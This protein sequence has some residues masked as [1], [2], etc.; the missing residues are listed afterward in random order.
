[1]IDNLHYLIPVNSN[2]DISSY[3]KVL[4][5][6]C[7]VIIIDQHKKIKYVNQKFTGV[8]GF[9]LKKVAGKNFQWLDARN[10]MDDLYQ[11]FWKKLNS[12]FTWQGE[13]FQKKT[14]NE[15]FWQQASVF[16]FKNQQGEVYQYICVGHD[17]T[18]Y[19]KAMQIKNQFLANMSHELRTPL[20]SIYSLSNLLAET[21]LSDEQNDYMENILNATNVLMRLLED[22][23][24]MN[25]IETGQIQ[26][27]HKL[28]NPKIIVESLYKMFQEKSKQKKIDFDLHYDPA[29]PE[30][31]SGDPYRLKQILIHLLENAFKY[32]PHGNIK[33]TCALKERN[34]NHTIFNFSI[35]DTGIG[36]SSDNLNL[37]Q[38]KFQQANMTD[39]RTY[40]G[41]GLGLTIVKKLIQL[42]NGKFEINS[43]ENIGTKVSFT[44]PMANTSD[45]EKNKDINTALTTD[46]TQGMRVLIA[47]DVDI[48]QLVIK[49]HMQK[50]G[51]IA[52]F[53]ENGKIA[54]E[55]LKKNQYHIVLM[56]MQMPVMDGYKAI[57]IIRNEL[58]EPIKNIPIISITASVMG[59]APRKCL[60]VG[61]NDYVPK[62]YNVKELK[63]KMEKWV[64]ENQENNAATLHHMEHNTPKKEGSLID[65]DYLEQLSEGDDDFTISMLSYFIDNT[66]SVIQEMKDFYK[67]KNWK[68]LRN[69][70]HKFKPQLT[71]MGI[72]SIFNDVENIEQN[73]SK[74]KNIDEIPKL[75]E[76]TEMIATKAMIEIQDELEKLLDK[77]Q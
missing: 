29:L 45:S 47:E 60:E 77:N 37:I 34:Q 26:F 69:V 27:D 53:A 23:L 59:E 57:S 5:E 13:L 46:E 50:F 66:P 32:T 58:P 9:S 71:F 33:M 74:V 55:K 38:E 7:I 11:K 25:K 1:M 49:K 12:G 68:A 20:H 3:Q 63:S 65:L 17:I 16:P 70:A 18:T 54:I 15:T 52:D 40:G 56:D 48:N 43:S 67:E 24:D 28:F 35:E 19:K 72:T 10:N 41:S 31:V 14:D 73:A 61:A 76:K 6:S 75:I 44:L 64:L 8:S 51:F 30:F 39:T 21:Q 4:D 36:I 42:Q 2:E 22:M 62:P